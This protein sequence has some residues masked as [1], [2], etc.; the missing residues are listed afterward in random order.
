MD[1]YYHHFLTSMSGVGGYFPGN[2]EELSMSIMPG[3]HVPISG[4]MMQNP[5]HNL[6]HLGTYPDQS[7]LHASKTGKG[8]KKGNRDCVYPDPPTSKSSKSKDN[9]F[10]KTSPKSSNE[11]EDADMDPVTK[12]LQTI[13]DKEEPEELSS[14]ERSDSQ[15][16][17]SKATGSSNRNVTTRQSTESSSPDGNK[18]SSPSV[19]TGGSS[20]TVAPSIDLNIPTDGRADWSHLPLDYQHYLNY[21]VENITSFHYS[22]MHDADDFFGTILPSLAVQHEPLL[23][24]VVGFATYHATLQ[25][26]AGKLQDFLKYYNKSVTLLLESINRKGMDNVLNLITILQLLTI[27]E[28]F[29]DWINL[30]GHQKAAFQ[31][32]RKIFTPD[33][34]M[35][36]PVGRACID[37]YTR[38]DC[39]VAIMG[40]FPTDLPREWFNRMNEYNESQL[41]ASPDE[42]RWKI[43]SRSTQLRSVSYDMSMLYARGSRGQIGP[44]DFTKEHKRITD[45][46]LEW[47]S[48]WD[49]A[50]SLPEYLVTDFSYQRD[51]DPGDI[52]NPY[53]PGLLY[54][55]PLFT[56]TL[57]TTEWTS[58]MLMHL[59]QSSDTPAEQVFMEMAK[60][61]YTICQ[62]FE[63]VELWPL[64]PKGA[65]IPLQ[66][67]IS[68]AA[69]FLPRD[70]RH[71]MWVRRKFALLDTMGFIHPTTRRIKMAH[72]F[73]DPSCAHWWLPNDEGLTPILQAIRAFADERN[74]AAVNAQHENI[75]EVRHLFAKMEAAELALTTGNDGTGMS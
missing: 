30:M 18:G 27:E 23:N 42:L 22:I 33:T 48:T 31:V 3:Y 61:A 8:C 34:V 6:G 45:E 51:V 35:H 11:G 65:L 62:Y 39:Y 58:I 70:S 25:N 38:Y 12:P 74:T 47:K 2:P 46:L 69:L 21:F 55:Q 73:R 75:R 60:H 32:I 29:G 10:Q 16:S 56:N 71:Q 66:P 5:Y 52:V 68:I 4:P 40:G 43:S 50:L 26:P 37:W 44:E 28:Y 53:M 54:K 49:A 17:G 64:K 20:V 41:G 67:C 59:S 15:L 63:T 24:A 1:E 19:S 57:I 14:E 13:L 9:T 72:L 36:T 7:L